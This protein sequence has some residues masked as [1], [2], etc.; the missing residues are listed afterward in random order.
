MYMKVK[1]VVICIMVLITVPAFAGKRDYDRL[2]SEIEVLKKKVTLLERRNIVL[3]DENRDYKKKVNYLENRI[4][5]LAGELE[6]TIKKH[7]KE[8]DA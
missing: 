4:D 8:I 7:A 1:L 5:N 3:E 6:E 2:R